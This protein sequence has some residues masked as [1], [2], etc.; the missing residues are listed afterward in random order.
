MDESARETP[1][2]SMVADGTLPDQDP[3]HDC[4]VPRDETQ[5]VGDRWTCPECGT[6]WVLESA[7]DHPEHLPDRRQQLVNWVRVGKAPSEQGSNPPSGL[8]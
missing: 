8:Y 1:S 2:D 5:G 4:Q 6:G 7:E 3:Q